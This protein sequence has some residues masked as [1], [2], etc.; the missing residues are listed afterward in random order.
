MLIVFGANGGIGSAVVKHYSEAHHE[1]GSV[2]GVTREDCELRDSDSVKSF[3]K[4]IPNIDGDPDKPW[5]VLNATGRLYNSLL[6][7]EQQIQIQDCVDST[8]VGSALLL[9][10]FW[11]LAP[12]GSRIVL[13][14]SVVGTKFGV[15]GA[16]IYGACKAAVEGLVRTASLEYGRHDLTASCI[17]MGYFDRGLIERIPDSH[18]ETIRRRIP[19]RRW[20]T[21][22]ELVQVL[23]LHF[24]CH[25]MN[26][27]ITE[28]SGGVV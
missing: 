23:D 21:I 15:P 2:F 26:G 14:S 28:I 3:M 13:L 16:G 22:D 9:K 24:N 8:I 6:R 17:R 1:Y 12:P 5:Y 7:K 11:L 25:Y 18:A 4:N 27:A 20:G 19:L 10:Y